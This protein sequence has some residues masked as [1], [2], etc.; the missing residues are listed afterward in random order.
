MGR[1]SGHGD[2]RQGPR[3][4]KG[5]HA[6][7]KVEAQAAKDRVRDAV[8]AREGFTTLRFDNAAVRDEPDGVMA[9]VLAHLEALPTRPLRDHPPHEGEGE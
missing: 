4:T 1:A 7:H 2:H 8:L 9:T 5:A 3:H 6:A